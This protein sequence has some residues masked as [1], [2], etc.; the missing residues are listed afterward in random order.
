MEFCGII[1]VI[2]GLIYFKFMKFEDETNIEEEFE[3]VV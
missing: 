2:A 1:F 3:A